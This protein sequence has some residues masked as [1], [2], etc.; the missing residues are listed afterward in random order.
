MWPFKRKQQEAEGKTA[1]QQNMERIKEF[2]FRG[3]Q[4]HAVIE[5]DMI[6]GLEFQ[7]SIIRFM[8]AVLNAPGPK[9][10]NY[11]GMKV[12]FGT[13]VYDF[14]MMKP[15]GLDPLKR[16]KELSDLVENL[17]QENQFLREQLE[18]V[19]SANSRTDT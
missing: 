11:V 10:V 8:D 17:S 5:A 1:F 19:K 15:S 18:K 7:E 14:C 9:F 13:K 2:T 12:D 16:N 6:V 3:D 4:V